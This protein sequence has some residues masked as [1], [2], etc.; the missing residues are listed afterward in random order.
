MDVKF[1]EIMLSRQKIQ[2]ASFIVCATKIQ[3]VGNSFKR[4]D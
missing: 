4:D 1:S 3:Y 2:C